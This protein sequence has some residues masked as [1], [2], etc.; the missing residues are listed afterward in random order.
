LSVTLPALGE[1]GRKAFRFGL[2]EMKVVSGTLLAL[3]TNGEAANARRKERLAQGEAVRELDRVS[4]SYQA[5]R[6]PAA[7]LPHCAGDTAAAVRQA[8]T[9]S[10]GLDRRSP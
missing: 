2:A 3:E 8:Q 5:Y 7:P 10:N 4:W 1:K 9:T 6:E